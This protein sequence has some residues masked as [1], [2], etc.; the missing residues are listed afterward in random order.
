MK[1]DDIPAH[2]KKLKNKTN[3]SVTCRTLGPI[4][5]LERHLPSDWWRTLFN[6]VYLK[7]DG[8]VVENYENTQAEIDFVIRLAGLEKNDRILDLCC[9]QGR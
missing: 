6:S 1:N 9:G 3:G 8:D 2:S 7:T 5:D 4:Q